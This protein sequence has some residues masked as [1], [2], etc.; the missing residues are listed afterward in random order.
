MEGVNDIRAKE[1]AILLEANFK[2][3]EINGMLW[4]KEG[5]CYGRKAALQNAHSSL[6]QRRGYAL[7][8]HT[9]KTEAKEVEVV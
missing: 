3:L 9:S 1:E 7:Y 5:V 4:E 2:P 8:D 6:F